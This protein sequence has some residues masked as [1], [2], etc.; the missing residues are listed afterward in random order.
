MC[1]LRIKIDVVSR[2]SLKSQGHFPRSRQLLPPVLVGF[3]GVQ[4]SRKKCQRCEMGWGVEFPRRL[5]YPVLMNSLAMLKNSLAPCDSNHAFVALLGH[6]GRGPKIPFPPTSKQ[7]PAPRACRPSELITGG[8]S[9]LYF[10][11]CRSFGTVQH[12][13]LRRSIVPSVR[14]RIS[15]TS[16]RGSEIGST[17]CCCRSCSSSSSLISSSSI[18][19]AC[20]TCAATLERDRVRTVDGA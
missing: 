10:V 19:A 3:L 12:R 18:A 14:L 11:S 15:K 9:S 5:C 4:G 17:T 8:A 6:A 16:W 1:F 13:S 2:L 20:M 7:R